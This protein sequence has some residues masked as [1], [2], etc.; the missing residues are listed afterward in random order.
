MP[1]LAFYYHQASTQPKA[2][3]PTLD[4]T[5]TRKLAPTQDFEHDTGLWLGPE[6]GVPHDTH[7]SV[8]E[9][10]DPVFKWLGSSTSEDSV[11][12]V[13]DKY[14]WRWLAF[15]AN[16]LLNTPG[17]Q[18]WIRDAS[19]SQERHVKHDEAESSLD[20]ADDA[21]SN[22]IALPGRWRST[23]ALTRK[24]CNLTP[25]VEETNDETEFSPDA[26]STRTGQ[27]PR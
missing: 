18:K 5:P 22:L 25:V 8:S 17:Y 23:T 4:P 16:L 20:A 10:P 26:A 7:C 6:L 1:R 19:G 3:P 13:S 12:D 24:Q 27:I 15:S 21:G 2:R 14:H 9:E 11:V